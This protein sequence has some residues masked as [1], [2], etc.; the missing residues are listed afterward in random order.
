MGRYIAR[1]LLAT[2]LVLLLVTLISFSIMHMVPGDPAV[3]M[4]GVGASADQVQRI[5]EQFGLGAPFLV[6]LGHWYAGLLRGDLGQS[7]LLG[8]SVAQAI[9]ER[10]PATLSLASLAFVL[11]AGLGIALG[12]VAAI[13][14]NTWVDHAVM[15]LA[16]VGVSVPGFWLGLILII[17]FSVVV[18]WLPAGGYVPLAQGAGAW[19]RAL[20]LPAASLALLQVGLLARITRSTVAETLQEDYVRTARAKGLS[21]WVV[22]GRH[23][24]GNAT[25]PV[26]TVLGISTSLLLSGSVVV[27]TVFSIPGLGRLMA[28]A[29]LARDYPVIQGGL[30]VTALLFVVINLAVDVLYAWLDPRIR[31]E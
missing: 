9:G 20:V 18:D 31:Y 1:R 27:E 16:V 26:M 2:V 7:I 29:I 25:I 30:L 17:L 15:S 10:L 6:R 12:T 24:F 23:A 4:A 21:T 19:F 28:T 14:P 11:T 8:R 3:V 13:R 22:V 5:R